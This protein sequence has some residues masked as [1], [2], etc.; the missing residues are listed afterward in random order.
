MWVFCIPIS[1]LNLETLHSSA[2]GP[3]VDAANDKV[4]FSPF[5]VQES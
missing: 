4:T 1:V 2:L 3:Q 5:L